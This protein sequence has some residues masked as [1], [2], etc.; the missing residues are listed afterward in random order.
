MQSGVFRASIICAGSPNSAQWE[1]GASGA[2]LLCCEMVHNRCSGI[3]TYLA[4]IPSSLVLRFQCQ[5]IADVLP[6]VSRISID[7]LKGILDVFQKSCNPAKR[8]PHFLMHGS[9]PIGSDG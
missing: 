9:Y 5:W 4:S 7:D 6:G 8:F 1:D 3:I 2:L